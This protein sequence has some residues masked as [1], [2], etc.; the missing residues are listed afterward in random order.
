M[1]RIRILYIATALV[2]GALGLWPI[3]ASMGADGSVIYRYDAAGRLVAASYNNG[4][5][6]IYTYDANSNRLSETTGASASAG[7]GVWGCFNW[8][9]ALWG[10]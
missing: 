8:S 5:C 1:R 7:A 9:G 4:L 6:V 3:E 2:I 10:N